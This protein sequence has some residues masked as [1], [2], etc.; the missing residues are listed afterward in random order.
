MFYLLSC[1]L[2]RNGLLRRK[3]TPSGPISFG[4][5]AV[6]FNT[7]IFLNFILISHFDGTQVGLGSAFNLAT[8]NVFSSLGLAALV[9]G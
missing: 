3:R 6:G 9:T 1:F 2:L 5:G 7:F 8:A 4:A